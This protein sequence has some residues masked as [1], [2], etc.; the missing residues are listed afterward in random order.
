MQKITEARLD[1]EENTRS[2][3]KHPHTHAEWIFPFFLLL[4]RPTDVWEYLMSN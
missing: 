3:L 2:A 1:E 4:D